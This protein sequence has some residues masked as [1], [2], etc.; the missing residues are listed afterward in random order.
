MSKM[1][2][3]VDLNMESTVYCSFNCTDKSFDG[4]TI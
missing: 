3:E 4:I 2:S 1:T